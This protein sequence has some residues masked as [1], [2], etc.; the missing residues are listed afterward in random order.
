[1]AVSS[2]GCALNETPVSAGSSAPGYWKL[3]FSNST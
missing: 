3:T 1:M 2:P